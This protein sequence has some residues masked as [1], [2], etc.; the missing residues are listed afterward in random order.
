MSSLPPDPPPRHRFFGPS[1]DYVE[2][3]ASAYRRLLLAVLSV[4]VV[5]AALPSTSWS[6]F[7]L[8][9]LQGVALLIAFDLTRR[10]GWLVRGVHG[11]VAVAVIVAGLDLV[12][13]LDSETTAGVVMLVGGLLVAL[14]PL[15]IVDAV[16][17]H[18][19]IELRTASAAITIYILFGLFFS[20][21]YN[22]LHQFDESAFSSA[23]ELSPASFQYLS[24]ITLCTVGY[25][26]ITPASD[27]ARTL[28]V[29]EALIGQLYLVT[30]LGLI[31]GNLGRDRRPA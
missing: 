18:P 13:D 26:D 4:F 12:F 24:F 14:A 22:G 9:T 25:G 23:S 21:V 5:S 11:V 30:I 3:P 1:P 28:T 27:L 15:A 10:R 7:L 29:L 2:A 17:H 6:R 16:R 31:V 8:V 19:Q 20:F